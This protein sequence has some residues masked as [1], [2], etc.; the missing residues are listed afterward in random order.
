MLPAVVHEVLF[1]ARGCPHV[2]PFFVFCVCVVG[3]VLLAVCWVVVVVGAG[4]ML[5]A[6][7]VL[8]AV[9]C[10]VLVNVCCLLMCVVRCALS[11][12]RGLM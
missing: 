3:C 9:V 8:L 7:C 12:V 1:V 5:A 10:C 2:S 4:L 6:R 11:V